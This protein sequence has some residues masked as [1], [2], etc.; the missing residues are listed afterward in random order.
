MDGLFTFGNLE[1]V[2]IP[3]AGPQA[4]NDPTA[5]AP[6]GVLLRYKGNLYRYVKF[7]NGR[8][9]VAAAVG[10]VA[11]WMT[12]TP[13]TGVFTVS[14]DQ[15]D[16]VAGVNGVAGVLGNVVT[17]LYYTWV[18]VGGIV[19]A[20]CAAGTVAGDK[21]TGS[22][23]D[24]TFARIAAAG[25]VTDVVFGVAHG[26]LNTTTGFATVLLQDMQIW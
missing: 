5:L 14:S 21:L 10:G 11:Y 22:A 13:S 2:E 16:S 3:Y 23:T 20:K 8:A 19:S 12:L 18:Q 15:T 17:N 25:A 4:A 9:D 24:L 6:I 26:A 7:N 1:T